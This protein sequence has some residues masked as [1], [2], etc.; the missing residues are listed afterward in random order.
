M[1]RAATVDRGIRA[2]ERDTHCHHNQ[3]RTKSAGADNANETAAKGRLNTD[4]KRE[5]RQ[6]ISDRSRRSSR[7]DQAHDEIANGDTGPSAGE[8][9]ALRRNGQEILFLRRG[10]ASE[11]SLHESDALT[12]CEPGAN[13]RM[14]HLRGPAAAQG[15]GRHQRCEDIRRAAQTLRS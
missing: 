6:E 3:R 4:Q 8:L 9:N 15:T 11:N 10:R 1:R 13:E 14:Q 7:L 12:A 2:R 5:V